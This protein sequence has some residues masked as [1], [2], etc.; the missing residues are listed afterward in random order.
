MCFL[1]V[2]RIFIFVSGCY[3]SIKCHMF[4]MYLIMIAYFCDRDTLPQALLVFVDQSKLA[5]RLEIVKK[6]KQICQECKVRLLVNCENCKAPFTQFSQR[7]LS[8]ISNTIPSFRKNPNTKRFVSVTEDE[9]ERINERAVS[10]N[11]LNGIC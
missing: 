9:T 7:P 6:I 1:Y 4:G 3:A 2:C 8:T 11:S 5:K 10:E